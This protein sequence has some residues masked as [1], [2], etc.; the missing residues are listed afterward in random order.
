MRPKALP[1]AANA[2]YYY[3]YYYYFV[4]F[5]SRIPFV[6]FHSYSIVFGGLGFETACARAT[7]VQ[8][9]GNPARF[10]LNGPSMCGEALPSLKAFA[11]DIWCT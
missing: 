7:R 10:K 2:Y 9:T 1:L 11:L 5:L 3:Y 6:L 8:S 4:V